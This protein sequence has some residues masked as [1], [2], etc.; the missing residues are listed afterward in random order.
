MPNISAGSSK[1]LKSGHTTN[2][3]TKR[4][5]SA[6]LFGPNTIVDSEELVLW[7][8]FGDQSTL[9]QYADGT[10]AIT[11]VDKAFRRVDNKSTSTKRLGNFARTYLN[12]DPNTTNTPRHSDTFQQ[13]EDIKG[14][15]F[16][17]ESTWATR[18]FEALV[19]S[20]APGFG[21][22][23]DGVKWSTLTGGTAR[24]MTT[25]IVKNRISTTTGAATPVSEMEIF[26]IHR[27]NTADGT[28]KK[29]NF[30]KEETVTTNNNT[31]TNLN[32][33]DLV[34]SVRDLHLGANSEL[35]NDKR[36]DL[37]K[38]ITAHT[39]IEGEEDHPATT[40]EDGFKTH[41][42][43]QYPQSKEALGVKK[44]IGTP[45]NFNYEAGWLNIGSACANNTCSTQDQETNAQEVIYEIIVID[46]TLSKGELEQ[47][48]LY[49]QEK[50]RTNGRWFTAS[51]AIKMQNEQNG[52]WDVGTGG[53][54]P[55]S[56]GNCLMWYDF[57]DLNTL[58]K[59]VDTTCAPGA[60]QGPETCAGYVDQDD[61]GSSIA[62]CFNKAGGSR[63]PSQRSPHYFRNAP[64]FDS[65]P[66]FSY[67]GGTASSET[68]YSLGSFVRAQKDAAGYRPTLN[69]NT[70]S[71]PNIYT[72]C[73]NCEKEL[74]S[75]T[76]SGKG[77]LVTGM[78]D[79]YAGTGVAAGDINNN[80]LTWGGE[81]YSA[82][83]YNRYT[84]FTSGSSRHQTSH[85][86]S[87]AVVV[88]PDNR[89]VTG[90]MPSEDWVIF[91]ADVP[92]WISI[93]NIGKVTLTL[94]VAKDTGKLVV[95]FQERDNAGNLGAFT[96]MSSVG[97]FTQ[98][99]C[100]NCSW[101]SAAHYYWIVFDAR[102]GTKA[103]ALYV[104][105]K[106]VCRGT[107]PQHILNWSTG[108]TS[109]GSAFGP[110]ISFGGRITNKD[111]GSGA[112]ITTGV[113]T[114]PGRIYEVLAFNTG[115]ERRRL[116]GFTFG[117]RNW[118]FNYLANKYRYPFRASG[119][120]SNIDNL[121]GW[122]DFNDKSTLFQDV[123][124]ST[125]VTTSG[126][127]VG[128]VNNKAPGDANGDKMGSF[129]RS[130]GFPALADQ[131][132]YKPTYRTLTSGKRAGLGY[133]DCQD[134][135]QSNMDSNTQNK[136]LIGGHMNNNGN[137]TDW[138]G[139]AT[140]KFSDLILEQKN[141]TVFIIA[142]AA[143]F[144][145]DGSDSNT[146]GVRT[147]FRIEGNDMSGNAVCHSHW[148]AYRW[149]TNSNGIWGPAFNISNHAELG[150]TNK[151]HDFKFNHVQTNYL[152]S[153]NRV[154]YTS[155]N[156][157]PEADP[158]NIRARMPIWVTDTVGNGYVPRS[159]YTETYAHNQNKMTATSE[160]NS[161]SFE[162]KIGLNTLGTGS[163]VSGEP[164]VSIG[165][166][167]S[168]GNGFTKYG[169][170]TNSANTESRIFE[171]I[172]FNKA[173]N[174]E[175]E[176]QV[177]SYLDFKYP[178]VIAEYGTMHGWGVDS[179]DV[180]DSVTGIGFIW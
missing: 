12:S 85:E 8:D 172:V 148:S 168:G 147:L 107:L 58:W 60:G 7:Y 121:V 155:H 30:F 127:L 57:T 31:K 95:K 25:F 76:T 83:G 124:G 49:F 126:Q 133:I 141:M 23:Q 65:F 70:T 128:R 180:E 94:Y 161:G 14:V 123:L 50:Y 159:G 100:T 104:N 99:D 167:S 13:R 145:I 71:I 3:Y 112:D 92:R 108:S 162:I 55:N 120:L 1:V 22:I 116:S 138:G 44:S 82:G 46:R 20:A 149:A 24:G 114:F 158:S 140:N 144:D 137:M 102:P 32:H 166:N 125:L 51:N 87:F 113:N 42:L 5:G 47:F 118:L 59:T 2:Q 154:I 152:A 78:F 122:W 169:W 157:G 117:Q 9:W 75:V 74:P 146:L 62:Y 171:I 139:V 136:G 164:R 66:G 106:V 64:N 81:N 48:N 170:G 160:R 27:T 174:E 88:K 10:G 38:A 89:I 119:W 90:A 33:Q 156:N 135:T 79:D 18:R 52:C 45:L 173:L 86:F 163:T 17:G 96:K 175:E 26:G 101:L 129:L 19:S 109:T 35:V 37:G 134:T 73:Q 84:Q 68:K 97:V 165:A 54:N 110:Q 93:N 36:Y 34:L 132:Q 105:Q 131:D 151:D 11:G 53:L 67:S 177:K 77:I 40:Y 15:T 72:V 4:K 63:S 153:G 143:S 43:K 21:G 29:I 61:H 28:L 98:E 111:V 91:E 130:F 16:Y 115:H 179:Y 150:G 41:Y 80:I 69:T 178:D 176:A 103:T 56:W 142:T 6:E 39:I